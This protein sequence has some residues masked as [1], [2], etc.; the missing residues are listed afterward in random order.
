MAERGA[1]HRAQPHDNGVV[2]TLVVHDT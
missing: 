1:A 2:L